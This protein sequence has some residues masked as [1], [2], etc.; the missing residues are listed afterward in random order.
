M[1]KNIYVFNVLITAIICG[2]CVNLAAQNKYPEPKQMEPEMSEF[3]TPQPAIVTPGKAT[4]NAIISP[5]S[6]AVVLFDGKDLSAWKSS[7]KGGGEP[8]WIVKDGILIATPTG[9][10]ETKQHFENFQLHIEWRISE[11]V[12][13]KGQGRGNSGVYMQ[14]LY[15]VQVLDSYGNETY[16]NGQAGSI[17][18]QSPPLVNAMRKPGEWN[19][20]DIIYSAPVFKKDGTYRIPPRVTVIHNGVVIQNNTTILGTTEYVGFPKVVKHGAGPILL[21]DHGNAVN[22]RNIW[23]REL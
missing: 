12:T 7:G 16:A 18:K 19:V 13:G 5:P 1:K 11:D 21:Q 14:G 4:E 8:K 22:F 3:W 10:I 17:Y 20:Y 9:S 15:E 23:I 2:Y 6:D